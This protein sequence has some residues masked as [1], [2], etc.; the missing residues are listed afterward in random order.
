[1]CYHSPVL[2]SANI[3]LDVREGVRVQRVALAQDGLQ[4]AGDSGL[5]H[6]VVDLRDRGVAVLADLLE[7]LR[8]ALRGLTIS[9]KP[10]P[11]CEMSDSDTLGPDFSRSRITFCEVRL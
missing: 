6:D 4:G 7:A 8:R 9:R 10:C 3:V 11:G 5:R 2:V 1:M